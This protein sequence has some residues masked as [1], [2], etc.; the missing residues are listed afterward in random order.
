MKPWKNEKP[1]SL[2]AMGLPSTE[3]IE[4]ELQREKYRQRYNRTV[5]STVF[6]LVT[7]A[8]AAILVA[9][10]LLPVLRIYG[11]S[12]EPSLTE[13]NIVFSVK[14]S[15]K[16]QRGDIIAFYL[17]NKVLVKRVIA[18]SGE[19]IDIDKDGQVTINQE[20]IDEPYVVERALG[21]CDIELPYQVPD[22]KIF[23]MG[24]YRATSVDSRNTAVGCIANEQLVGRIVFRVWPLRSLGKVK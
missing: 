14:S 19:W 23:V 13:G 18:F 11:T 8:A 21:D 22:G 5:Q 16:L 1:R 24:D 4:A 12:M 9:T 17:N 20:Q 7:V 10:L 15:S 6:A 2:E 3:V